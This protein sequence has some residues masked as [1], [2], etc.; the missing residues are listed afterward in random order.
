MNKFTKLLVAIV[1]CL[2]YSCAVDSTADIAVG[3][4]GGQTSVTISLEET[5]THLGEKVGDLYPLYWS[6]GDKI[7]INGV[8]SEA[9]TEEAHGKTVAY[10]S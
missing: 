1:A 3:I 8:A 5:K 10:L 4:D 2:A 6:E 9:L 7:A